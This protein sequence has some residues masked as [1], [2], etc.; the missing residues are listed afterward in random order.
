M[1]YFINN[2]DFRLM[3]DI[4]NNAK[5]FSHIVLDNFLDSDVIA[6]IVKEFPNFDEEIWYVYDSA[7]EIKKVMNSWDRFSPSIY[8]LFWFLNS[9]AF[10]SNL[11][12]LTG[13]KLYPDFG[14][15]GGGLHS[16]RSGG[17]LNTHLDYSIHPKLKLERRLNLLIYVTPDWQLEWG[18]DLGLWEHD[19]K[20]NKPGNLVSTISPIFNRAVLFDTTQ[21][22]WHGLPEPIRCPL[23]V[24]RNSLAVYY[25]CEPRLSAVD[26]NR[27]L[28]VPYKQQ[29]NDPD[30]LELIQKRSD[31]INSQSVYRK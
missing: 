2:F 21:N 19:E 28:F 7:I 25:L 30:I 14:L 10:I 31:Y 26:R 9:D 16:H 24:T 18:G 23:N 29:E 13:C 8:K 5:P 6:N 3:A 17:K 15:N 12:F 4:W 20:L 1:D 11:E 27:A 22:S